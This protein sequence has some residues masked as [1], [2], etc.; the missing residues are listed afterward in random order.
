[1]KLLK[2][3]L[4]LFF[5]VINAAVAAAT[6]NIAVASNFSQPARQLALKFEQQSGVSVLISTGSTQILAKQLANGAPYDV[7][8]AADESTP[9]RLVS[10]GY[11]L[12]GT[13]FTYAHGQLVLWSHQ[14]GFIKGDDKVLFTNKFKHLAIANPKLAPYGAVAEQ[15]IGQLGLTKQLQNKIIQGENISDTYQ[16]VA[17]DNAELGFIALSQVYFD[18]KII[19][20][21]AWIVPIN[22][23]QLINQDAV[24]TVNGQNNP[25]A[26]KFM[27]FLKSKSAWQ[28]INRYGYK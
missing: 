20:G 25:A 17:S 26:A 2:N 14:S 16:Y 8:L 24:I 10:D 7:F 3:I 15:V 1:M 6:L 5:I 21:S 13:Q 11:A 4:L 23:A 9:A 19:S 22:L 28:I 27:S 12:A 18:G